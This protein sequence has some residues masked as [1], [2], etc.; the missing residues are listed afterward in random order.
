MPPGS[1]G[2]G[3]RDRCRRS[4]SSSSRANNESHGWSDGDPEMLERSATMPR[5]RWMTGSSQPLAPNWTMTVGNDKLVRIS[6]P[7]YHFTG[8]RRPPSRNQV[9]WGCH[10][11][12]ASTPSTVVIA[13][14]STE[15]HAQGALQG[16]RPKR[17]G[18]LRPHGRLSTITAW[19]EVPETGSRRDGLPAGVNT[20][21]PANNSPLSSPLRGPGRSGVDKVRPA[22]NS[23]TPPD[24]TLSARYQNNRWPY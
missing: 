1:N 13:S 5:A 24:Y 23:P 4:P 19:D 11:R 3:D 17:A 16:T 15:L 21:R 18:E 6:A 14:S 20:V 7:A 12:G 8:G 2:R 10:R 9:C 22:S